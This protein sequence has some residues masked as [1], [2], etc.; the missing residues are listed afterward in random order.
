MNT[1]KMLNADCFAEMS[2]IPDRSFPLV[3]T[4]I[5]Y[6]EVNR[7]S[8]GLRSLDK[9]DAD[10]ASFDVAEL[11]RTLCG[12]TS[13]SVYVF[14]GINQLSTIRSTMT[15]CGLS[16]RVIVWEKT[17]PSPMNGTKI[18]LSGIEL[19]AFGKRQGGGIPR[20]L[21]ELRRPPSV[22]KA[23]PA[24]DAEAALAHGG[25][26]RTLVESRRHG[27]RPVHGERN[28]G[29][30]RVAEGPRVLR[31]RTERGVF[32]GRERQGHEARV[33]INKEGGNNK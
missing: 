2:A 8:N 9:R 7:K 19:C 16:T 31:N 22:R 21:P 3:L 30:R 1:V 12:K 28:D 11:T 6:G 26:H 25:A 15:E 17:N 18:W 20:T 13:G 32:Q 10:T 4:D 33:R 14:C 5:P 24:P 23:R 27:I 29:R